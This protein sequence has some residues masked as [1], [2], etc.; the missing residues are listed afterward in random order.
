MGMRFAYSFTVVFVVGS[1]LDLFY[2]HKPLSPYRTHLAFCVCVCT[3]N[4][5]VFL[6]HHSANSIRVE[7]MNGI[8]DCAVLEPNPVPGT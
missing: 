3:Q 6:P 8:A 1:T 2:P 7:S 5:S 4:V